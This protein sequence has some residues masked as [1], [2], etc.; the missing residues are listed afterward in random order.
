MFKKLRIKLICTFMLLL[1]ALVAMLLVSFYIVSE[2]NIKNQEHNQPFNITEKIKINDEDDH[3]KKESMEELKIEL[4]IIGLVSVIP[5]LFLSIIVANAS[6]KP[7]EEAYNAQKRF[8]A[9]AS[10]ELKTPIAVI[11]TNLDVL[12]DNKQDTIASQ[13]KWFNYIKFQTGRMSKLIENLLY[14]AKSDNNEMLGTVS[15]FNL[16][17][18][19]TN[20]LL[21]FEAVA[22][23]KGLKIDYGK[24]EE[25]IYFKGNKDSIDQLVLILLDNAAKYAYKNSEI[26]VSLSVKKQKIY[27]AVEN[28]CD[29][30]PKENLEKL[31]DRFYRIEESRARQGGGY[32]LGLSI[33]KSIAEKNHGKIEAKSQ[34]NKVKFIVEFSIA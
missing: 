25:N 20:I 18:A 32:G 22:F 14:L 28:D 9:D 30:I 27:F 29:T 24:V 5:L 6:I 16:S 10:H 4:I 1:T 2:R 34:D 26:K 15:D 31:F 17:D 7:V 8:I 3:S 11:N 21:S 19:I 33:A 13:E 23:E 12:E